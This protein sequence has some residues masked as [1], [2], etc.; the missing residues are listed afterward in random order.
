MTQ[1]DLQVQDK[2]ELRAEGES[3]R[4]VPVYLPAVDIFESDDAL[5]LIADMPGVAPE[6]VCIDLKDNQLTIHGAATVYGEGEQSLLREYGVGDYQRQFTLGKM[7]DQS[8]IEALMKDGVLT[9]TLPKAD[10]AKP[11]KIAVKTH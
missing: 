5:T 7:V 6:E 8:K 1:K 3:T 4:N 10:V 9:V 11:R 2:Q